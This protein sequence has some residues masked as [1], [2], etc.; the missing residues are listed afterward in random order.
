MGR[1]TLHQTKAADLK[2]KVK[3]LA[4]GKPFKSWNKRTNRICDTCKSYPEQA[5]AMSVALE[6]GVNWSRVHQT[7][8]EIEKRLTGQCLK[9]PFSHYH[10]GKR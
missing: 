4:C 7:L 9:R 8:A 1:V 6:D 2:Y 5:R 10:Y 3:C